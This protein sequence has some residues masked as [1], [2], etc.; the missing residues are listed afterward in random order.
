MGIDPHTDD[1]ELISAC[2]QGNR[3]A[4]RYLYERYYGRLM[5]ICMRYANDRE[6]ALEVLNTAFLKIFQHLATYQPTGPLA[7]W[8]ARIVFRTAIDHIRS[9]K[10]YRETIRFPEHAQDHPEYGTALPSLE[11]ED[12]LRHLRALPHP[13]RTVFTLYVIDGYRHK[14]IG[15]MLGFDESTSRWYL[16]QVRKQLQKKLTP[17][18]GSKK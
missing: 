7:G 1:E 15:E 16:A 10:T 18:S 6:D 13:G 9:R 12:I 3:L 4:Q 14:D 8:M 2:L 17:P 11:A 5:S